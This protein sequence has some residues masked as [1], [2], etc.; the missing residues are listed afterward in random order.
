MS[1]GPSTTR[2]KKLDAL[3]SRLYGTKTFTAGCTAAEFAELFELAE[4]GLEGGPN[5][6][7]LRDGLTE[8]LKGLLEIAGTDPLAT[9]ALGRALSVLKDGA[10][11][12]L[13]KPTEELRRR[14]PPKHH[15]SVRARPSFKELSPGDDEDEYDETCGRLTLILDEDEWAA[16]KAEVTGQFDGTGNLAY[17]EMIADME[18]R[19]SKAVR[20]EVG[21]EQTDVDLCSLIEGLVETAELEKR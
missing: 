12:T 7:S 8:T 18:L 14:K 6:K 4:C 15:L 19:A 13:R 10:H 3:R 1:N 11:F 21:V 16:V 5:V 20:D 9:E 17:I 2:R